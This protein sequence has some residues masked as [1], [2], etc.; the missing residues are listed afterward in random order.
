MAN[1]RVKPLSGLLGDVRRTNNFIL[2]I[3]GV[4]TPDNEEDNNL[5]LIIQQAFIPS[6]SLNVLELR[7]GNDAKKFAGVATWT[8]GQV[9][10]IDVLSQKELDA[11]LDWF[12]LTYDWQTGNIG[13]A[14][15][16]KKNGYITEYASNGKFERKW[17]IEGMWISDLN[18][19]DLDASSG[20]M[21]K[22][23]MTIQI[24]PS[25]NFQP[26]YLNY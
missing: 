11:V 1:I 4:T 5:E 20:E 19:G 23:T 13:V 6:V 8:G 12:K 26:E 18:I 25:Q 2:T 9:T 10:V 17:Y 24:D 16:Y 7:H 15:E 14:N 21:K 22:I 3:G